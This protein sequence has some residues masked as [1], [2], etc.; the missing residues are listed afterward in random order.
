MAF[1]GIY[2]FYELHVN[3]IDEFSDPCLMVS[4]AELIRDID[5]I[6]IRGEQ[7]WVR[8]GYEQSIVAMSTGKQEEYS[9]NNPYLNMRW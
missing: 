6:D 9:P 8:A 4:E 5:I 1:L 7:L 2:I 3:I